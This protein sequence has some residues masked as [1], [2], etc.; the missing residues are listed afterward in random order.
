MIVIGVTIATGDKG[1]LTWMGLVDIN[2]FRELWMETK[3]M[4]GDFTVSFIIKA[5]LLIA[6]ARFQR[7]YYHFFSLKFRRMFMQ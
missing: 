1:D 5:I 7:I 4:K 6:G 3:T 2:W